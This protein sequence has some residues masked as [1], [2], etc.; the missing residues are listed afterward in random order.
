MFVSWHYFRDGVREKHFFMIHN[1]NLPKD[2]LLSPRFIA[3]DCASV[4]KQCVGFF[5]QMV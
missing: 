2:L 1:E 3:G 5:N 4:W